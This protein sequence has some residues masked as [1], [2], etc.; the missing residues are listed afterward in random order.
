MKSFSTVEERKAI[1]D[2][3]TGSILVHHKKG[4]KY[5]VLSV[6]NVI[7]LEWNL[8]VTYKDIVTNAIF[9]RTYE[10]MFLGENPKFK[11]Y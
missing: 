3:L 10:E 11:V 4:T 1:Q 5:L 9:T 2:E 7:A 6:S 8:Y